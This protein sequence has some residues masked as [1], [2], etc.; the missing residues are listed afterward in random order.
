MF[1]DAENP[2]QTITDRTT[3]KEPDTGTIAQRKQADK[4]KCKDQKGDFGELELPP[5]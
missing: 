3:F 2:K 1:R 5:L 4:Q